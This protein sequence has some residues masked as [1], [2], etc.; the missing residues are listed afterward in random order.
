[1]QG[2]F[3]LEII[4]TDTSRWIRVVNPSMKVFSKLYVG[5]RMYPPAQKNVPLG[6]A[7]PYEDNAAGRKRQETVD[8]WAADT[9]YSY[10]LDIRKPLPKIPSRIIDNEPLPG[11]KITD[12]IKRVYWGGGNVVWRVED[13]RGFELEIQSE[14]LMAIIQSSGILQG[15]EIPGRCIW[16]RADGKNILLHETSIEYK[17]SI[18]AAE[19]LKSPK[20]IPKKEKRIGGLYTC[21][22]GRLVVYLGKVYINVMDSVKT[23][24]NQDSWSTNYNK[25]LSGVTPLSEEWIK[26][27]VMLRRLAIHASE[28]VIKPTVEY[29]AVLELRPDILIN[30]LPSTTDKVTLYKN[31][32]LIADERETYELNI[33]NEYL[34]NFHYTFANPPADGYIKILRVALDP[35]KNPVFGTVPWT[36]QQYTNIRKSLVSAIERNNSQTIRYSDGVAQ[37]GW[38]M[39]YILGRSYDLMNIPDIG[40]AGYLNYIGEH[41]RYI[42]GTPSTPTQNIAIPVELTKH[43]FIYKGFSHDSRYMLY[44]KPYSEP[45]NAFYDHGGHFLEDDTKEIKVHVFPEFNSSDEFLSWY[46]ELY[47]QKN[48]LNLTVIEDGSE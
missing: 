20:K 5:L 30:G 42:S 17:N 24:N 47:E 22:G 44:M 13:P 8:N 27:S 25:F 18:K 41:R 33:D 6:F 21:V 38:P 14:N 4:M 31:A 19:N 11:F 46:D 2:I 23:S 36:E 40:L 28:F 45:R 43:R 29:E 16:G 7:T 37:A 12:D 48:L 26:T 35:I 1:M 3:L 34:R 15:G 9:F 10:D 39:H 32:P